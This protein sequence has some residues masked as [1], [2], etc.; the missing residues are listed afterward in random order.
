MFV[1]YSPVLLFQVVNLFFLFCRINEKI[2]G[3]KLN[4]EKKR[5][6][7]QFLAIIRIL[8]IMSIVMK[9]FRGAKK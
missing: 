2:N 4:I 1:I 7:T 8:T 3:E 5:I 9:I 6:I